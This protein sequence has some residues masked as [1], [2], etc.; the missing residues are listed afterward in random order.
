MANI[1]RVQAAVQSA[2]RR[3]KNFNEVETGLNKAQAVSECQRC[4]QCSH[5]ECV[6]ACPLG[7]DIPGVIRMIREN[8]FSGALQKIRESNSLAGICGRICSAP[9]EAA[10]ILNTDKNPQPIAIRCL[11][12]AAFDF[13]NVKFQELFNAERMNKT[14]KKV[15]V[16][17]SGPAGLMA[18]A[19]LL[20]DGHE[21]VLFEALQKSGGSLRY[22]VPEFRLPKKVLDTEIEYVSSLGVRMEVNTLVGQARTVQQLF[23][24]GYD[25]ILLA[26]G[27]SFDPQ[28]LLPGSD[29]LGVLTAQEFLF[30]INFL[31]AHL[32]PKFATALPEGKRVVVVQAGAD[33]IDCARLALRLGRMATLVHPSTEDDVGTSLSDRVQAQEEGVKMEVLTKPLEVVKDEKGHAKGV[34]CVRLDFA[35]DHGQWK[36]IPVK[37]SA[38]ILDA[39]MVIVGGSYTANTAVVALTPGLTIQRQNSLC[40]K[41]GQAATSFKGVFAA[42]GVARGPISFIEAL[43]QGKAA[44]DEIDRY[45]QELPKKD[46]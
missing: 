27:I 24:R 38:F 34:R 43:A 18:S 25:A 28:G 4:P 29:A 37:D 22:G 17:G 32:H 2:A 36:L 35:D 12:R 19:N 31:S 11:E 7:I 14:G 9:C 33:G 5:P 13:G 10:C 39:D 8:D 1:K 40:T 3:I 30:R 21:V 44:A 23:D 26:T 45:L 20:E 16:V 6:K 15:A 41:K 42:G 46:A